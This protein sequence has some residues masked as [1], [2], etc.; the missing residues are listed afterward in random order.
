MGGEAVDDENLREIIVGHFSRKCD[1]FSIPLFAALCVL[2][3]WLVP[4]LTSFSPSLKPTSESINEVSEAGLQAAVPVFSIQRI[5]LYFENRRPDITVQREYPLKAFADIKYTGSG[6]FQ[7]YWEVDGKALSYVNQHII[8]GQIVTFESPQIPP[9]PTFNPGSHIVRFVVTN[10]SENIPI[11]S[12][13]Y[14]VM[15]SEFKGK[16]LAVKLISPKDKAVLEYAPVKFDWEGFDQNTI[17]SIQFFK[18]GE[19]KPVFSLCV[20]EPLY[21]LTES[22]LKR[23]FISGEKYY[24][25]IKGC[26]AE[27]NLGE[28]ETREFN[29]KKSAS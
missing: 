27:S 13:L 5:E 14:F 8:S 10:P 15:P 6:L 25:R 21:T 19:S 2:L 3:S 24:W 7:G 29:F 9:L 26:S 20:F 17:Y 11:P 1:F 18:H 23:N 16:Y 12:A 28:S 22:V 4:C